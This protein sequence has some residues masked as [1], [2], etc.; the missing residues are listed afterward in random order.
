MMT[1]MPGLTAASAN[2][3]AASGVAPSDLSAAAANG[4]TAD[5]FNTAA[6]SLSTTGSA[7]GVST[8]LQAAGI[9]LPA[10]LANY[11]V[12]T[13]KNAQ[14]NPSQ[15]VVDPTTGQV[16]SSSVVGPGGTTTNLGAATSNLNTA[17]TTGLANVSAEQQALYNQAGA[18]QGGYV[19]SVIAPVQAQAGQS[20]AQQKESQALRGLSGSSLADQ[21]LSNTGLAGSEAVSNATAQ[22]LQSSLTLQGNIASGQSATAVN[23]SGLGTTI[24]N[25]NLAAMKMGTVPAASQQASNTAVSNA[26]GSA[27]SGLSGALT[28]AA[29]T[30]ATNAIVSGGVQWVKDAATGLWK[31]ATGLLSSTQPPPDLNAASTFASSYGNSGTFSVGGN[32][33]GTTSGLGGSTTGGLSGTTYATNT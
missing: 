13:V 1:A 30:A 15:Y 6:S 8:A 5:T 20:L 9:V 10:V 26:Q 29:G 27:L 24:A 23:Q 14:V 31:S 11:A 17:A 25:Q 28:S 3:L 2:A 18:N 19:Q 16:I 12:N 32:T 7:S 4:A 33:Y 22:A 21:S